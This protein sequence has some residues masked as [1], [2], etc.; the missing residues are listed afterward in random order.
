MSNQQ[1]NADCRMIH[2]TRRIENSALASVLA[3]RLSTCYHH[4]VHCDCRWQPTGKGKAQ[5]CWMLQR[6]R[7][8][9]V[10]WSESVRKASSETCPGFEM[11]TCPTAKPKLRMLFHFDGTEHSFTSSV[12]P[13]GSI[14]LLDVS[15]LVKPQSHLQSHHQPPATS[16]MPDA[17]S[18]TGNVAQRV[19]R[20]LFPPVIW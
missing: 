14:S 4:I 12:P 8:R 20:R 9:I 6:Y 5:R 17:K 3:C 18:V 11:Q 2:C 1:R 7:S 13:S 16:K 19:P 10:T 15:F